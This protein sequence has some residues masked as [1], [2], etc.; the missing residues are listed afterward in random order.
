ML[1]NYLYEVSTNLIRGWYRCFS[2]IV[3][4]VWDGIALNFS[5]MVYYENGFFNTMKNSFCLLGL[6]NWKIF[7]LYLLTTC[8]VIALC[9]FN[10]ITLAIGLLL[11]AVFNS[12]VIILYTLISHAGFDK[13]INKENYPDMVG[14]GLYKKV[15]DKEA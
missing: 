15:E 6:L 11:F 9:C 3:F 12:V 2:I 7:V 4:I 8:G 14:K 5:Q 1:L 13:Y 10:M